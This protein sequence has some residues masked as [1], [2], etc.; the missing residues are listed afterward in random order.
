MLLDS[1]KCGYW[2]QTSAHILI[3]IILC[4]DIFYFDICLIPGLKKNNLLLAVNFVYLHKK[5]VSF[6]FLLTF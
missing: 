2:V 1:Q 5:L 3:F 4:I 6:Q